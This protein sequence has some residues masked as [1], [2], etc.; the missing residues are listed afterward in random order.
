MAVYIGDLYMGRSIELIANNQYQPFSNVEDATVVK[1]SCKKIQGSC[2][3]I[4]L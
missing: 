3:L 1:S 4:N 2:F